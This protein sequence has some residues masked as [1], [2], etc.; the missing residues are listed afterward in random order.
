[1]RRMIGDQADQPGETL[2]AGEAAEHPF[3]PPEEDRR[4]NRVLGTS[5]QPEPSLTD[6]AG[7]GGAWLSPRGASAVIAPARRSAGTRVRSG[8]RHLAQRHLGETTDSAAGVGGAGRFRYQDAEQKPSALACS[9][10]DKAA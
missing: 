9:Q 4:D 1:M 7:G 2:T 8:K 5:I 10:D 3:S 6:A